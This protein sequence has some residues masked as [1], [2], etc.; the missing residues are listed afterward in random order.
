MENK[1][2]RFSLSVFTYIF[3]NELSKILL[4]KRNE[5]KRRKWGFD[6]GIVGGCVEPGEFLINAAVREIKEETGIDIKPE[7]LVFAHFKENP[8]EEEV[9]GVQFFYASTL[10]ENKNVII[11]NESDEFRWFEI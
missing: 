2:K 10:E 5:E 9:S 8:S 1:P 6:W 3:N 11:N 7:N 4:I